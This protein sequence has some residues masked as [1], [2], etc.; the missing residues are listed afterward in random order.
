MTYRRPMKKTFPY[1]H[2]NAQK[3]FL[4][5]TRSDVQLQIFRYLATAKDKRKL[6]LRSIMQTIYLAFWIIKFK[7]N[8]K[9]SQS[10]TRT[11]TKACYRFFV[12]AHIKNLQQAMMILRKCKRLG[13]ISVHIP[14]QVFGNLQFPKSHGATWS[15]GWNQD[16]FWRFSTQWSMIIARDEQII[17]VLRCVLQKLG[18]TT[19]R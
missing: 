9:P 12:N 2:Y 13:F 4:L 1:L 17:W 14:W 5:I 15:I 16:H 8:T 7:I 18:S 19:T 11:R 3:L 6:I 10:E